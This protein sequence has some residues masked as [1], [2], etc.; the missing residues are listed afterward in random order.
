MVL[1]VQQIKFDIMRYVKEIGSDFSEW[2]IGIESCGKGL[3]YCYKIN[4]EYKLVPE[5]GWCPKWKR[6]NGRLNSVD[7]ITIKKDILVI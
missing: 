6:R 4:G 2:Y 3:H 7:F 5:Q 1:S